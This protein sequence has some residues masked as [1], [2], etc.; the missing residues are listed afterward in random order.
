MNDNYRGRLMERKKRNEKTY[1]I[2]K[3]LKKELDYLIWAINIDPDH[4]LPIY[5][6][7]KLK[8]RDKI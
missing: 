8:E 5:R 6:C 7:D 2:K 3:M 1:M 4:E